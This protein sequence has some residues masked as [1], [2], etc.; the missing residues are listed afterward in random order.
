MM[1]QCNSSNATGAQTRPGSADSNNK[2]RRVDADLSA[3]TDHNTAMIRLSDALPTGVLSHVASFLAAPSRALF[4]ATLFGNDKND[5]NRSKIAGNDWDTLDF[6]DIEAALAAKLSDNHMNAILCCIDAVRKVKKLRLTN[7]RT[8]S[9]AGLE[10]L[11]GSVVIERIDLRINGWDRTEFAPEPAISCDDAIPILE[12]IIETEGSALIHL[13]FPKKWRAARGK[14]GS[15]FHHFLLQYKAFLGD[16]RY[17]NPCLECDEEI[18]EETIISTNC[19]SHYGIQVNRCL[20]CLKSNYY[21]SDCIEEDE[22]L[23]EIK[24]CSKCEKV[25]CGDCSGVQDC[26]YCGA[27]SCEDCIEPASCQYEHGC[28][29]GDGARF[30]SRCLLKCPGCERTICGG[31]SATYFSDT[32]V[33][34]IDFDE[35]GVCYY[36]SQFM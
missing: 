18:K 31:C 15:D 22:N 6:G 5:E 4:A 9:G 24:V 16:P 36:C 30:C 35:Y 28:I 29:F 7:C 17:I 19:H 13:Q 26:R 8:I 23:N 11:R 27:P 34:P 32:P 14:D 33:G 2:R 12:S 3:V 1:G 21:C 25:D 20:S 10:P